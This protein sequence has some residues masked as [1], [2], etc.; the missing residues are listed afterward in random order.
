[1]TSALS[2]GFDTTVLTTFERVFGEKMSR[3]P[4][5]SNMCRISSVVTEFPKGCSRIDNFRLGGDPIKRDKSAAEKA[6]G[7][8]EKP[9]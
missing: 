6:P 2:D 5:S 4:T 3:M 9:K 8:S 1:M 7:E